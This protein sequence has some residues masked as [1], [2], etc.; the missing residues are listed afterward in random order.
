MR[1]LAIETSCDET[2]LAI[3]DASGGL[4]TPQFKIIK[5][6]VS[7]QIETHRP[8]GG[9]VPNLAKR[10]HTKNLPKIFGRIM[11]HESEIR[12]KKTI[13]QNSKFIIPAIDL[14]AVT[15][16]PGLE[17]CLWAGINFAKEIHAQLKTEL[18]GVN[19]LEGHLYSFLLSGK[20]K[21]K[22][23]KIFP[24]IALIVSGGHT[25]LIL[26]RSLTSWK[27]LGETRDD[28]VGEA[29]DKIA[30][31]LKLPYP[32]GPEIEKLA[33][34]GNRISKDFPRPM[35]HAKNY[36]FSFSGLKTSVLY[37]LRDHKRVKKADV[38]ASFQ[39]AAIDVLVHKTLRAAQE[40][41][42]K[43]V[44]LSGG[45][46]SNK[47]LRRTLKAACNKKNLDFIVAP[48]KYNTD[49]G[50]MIAVAAYINSLKKPRRPPTILSGQAK[51]S[52]SLPRRQAGRPRGASR[53]NHR[54]CAQGN[55]NL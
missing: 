42:A 35:M 2:A 51:G 24:A 9:V 14:I 53:K 1:I 21:E 18:V 31:M 46:A 22:R 19:H 3:V 36:D 16:G 7:S 25:M 28:A 52:G 4:R 26:M 33:I 20:R 34:F 17:P 50:V 39:Q 11:N 29:F 47:A 43:S 6:I 5:H 37:Y 54:L 40:F 38:A 27:K 32:G 49:N 44:M 48:T 23:E 15:V 41:G 13:I 45:V 8:W 10:E 30:R 55:L 12:K